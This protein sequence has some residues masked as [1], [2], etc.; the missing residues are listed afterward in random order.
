[1]FD[2][3]V[4]CV[5]TQGNLWGNDA[6]AYSA[7]TIKSGSAQ[8]PAVWTQ[9]VKA[10]VRALP[11]AN[12]STLKALVRFHVEASLPEW[13]TTSRMRPELF[14]RWHFPIA[15][16]HT[17]K[18]ALLHLVRGYDSLLAVMIENYEEVFER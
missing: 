9:R 15:W 3:Y 14:A 8:N 7:K 17:S 5:G 4:L 18:P 16:A 11:A 13:T 2:P 6:T 12:Q 1:M 10:L